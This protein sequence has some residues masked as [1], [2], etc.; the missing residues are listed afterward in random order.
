MPVLRLILGIILQCA[1][2][3]L[4]PSSLHIMHAKYL[5]LLL[6]LSLLACCSIPARARESNDP[7]WDKVEAEIVDAAL[8]RRTVVVWIVDQTS[9][10]LVIKNLDRLPKLLQSANKIAAE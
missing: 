6:L 3:P 9:T 5:N 1:L 10:S 2:T 4:A 8:V 7:A